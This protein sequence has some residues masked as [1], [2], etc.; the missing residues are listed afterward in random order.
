[1]KGDVER[2]VLTIRQIAQHPS[3]MAQHSPIDHWRRTVAHGL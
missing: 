2:A 1:M 3:C